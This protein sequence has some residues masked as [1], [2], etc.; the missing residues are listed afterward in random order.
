[1]YE[2]IEIVESMMLQKSIQPPHTFG[3]MVIPPV[4]VLVEYGDKGWSL[5]F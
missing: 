4:Y 3:A 5:S 1:M 2:P